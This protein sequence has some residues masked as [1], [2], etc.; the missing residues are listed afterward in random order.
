MS[1]YLSLLNDHNCFNPQRQATAA[2]LCLQT[3][4]SCEDTPRL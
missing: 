1:G 2:M 4:V 3:A